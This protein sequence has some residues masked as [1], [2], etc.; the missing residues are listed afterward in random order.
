MRAAQTRAA[1][2][3]I[4]WSQEQLAEA[5][6]LGLSTIRDFEKGRRVPTHNNPLG[7]KSA[8]ETAGVEFIP[9]NGGGAGVRLRKA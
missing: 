4:E 5:A 7:I 9:E 6:H 2:G 1:R 3:L 8:L